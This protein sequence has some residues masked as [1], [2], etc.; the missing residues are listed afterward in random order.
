MVQRLALEASV[1]DKR[2]IGCDRLRSKL[3]SA[4]SVALFIT[5]G[6]VFG[7]DR[8]RGL[9][10]HRLHGAPLGVDNVLPAE[11][12]PDAMERALSHGC[13]RARNIVAAR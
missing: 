7:D 3:M 13:R 1:I 2:R 10:Q 6:T 8:R 5:S 9:I 11:K 4:E 12:I